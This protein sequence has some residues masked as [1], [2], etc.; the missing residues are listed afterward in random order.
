M[1]PFRRVLGGLSCRE[2]EAAAET[3]SEAFGL[4]RS[5]A[6]RRSIR[7]SARALRGLMERRLDDREWLVLVIDG[8]TTADCIVIAVGVTRTGEKRILGMVQTGP[9][10]G[11][12]P[13]HT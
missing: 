3:V 5:S 4:A 8:K 9:G 11:R 12:R 10:T 7:A 2:Y 1:E 13:R 6:S